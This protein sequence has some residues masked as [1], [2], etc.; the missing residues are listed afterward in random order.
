MYVRVVFALAA[1][2][3]VWSHVR[4][5]DV[6]FSGA[7]VRLLVSVVLRLLDSAMITA[8]HW[9]LLLVGCDYAQSWNIVTETDYYLQYFRDNTGS[10]QYSSAYDYRS[11]CADEST[12]L[13]C[14]AFALVST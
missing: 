13:T 2:G 5:V 14:I 7:V 9:S 10:T 11:G 6:G 1:Y 3:G 4:K 12:V 8:D